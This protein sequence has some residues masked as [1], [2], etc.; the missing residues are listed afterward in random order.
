V[1]GAG[2]YLE[3]VG[4]GMDMSGTC[5]CI[6]IDTFNKVRTILVRAGSRSRLFWSSGTC[7]CTDID[8]FMFMFMMS[9]TCFC[10]N[11][12]VPQ[13]NWIYDERVPMI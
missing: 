9:G 4:G 5:F 3:L 2:S 11:G 7:F 12:D 10:T 8:T 13:N 6:D 1:V